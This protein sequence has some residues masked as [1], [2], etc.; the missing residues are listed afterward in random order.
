MLADLCGMPVAIALRVIDEPTIHWS[1]LMRDYEQFTDVSKAVIH[2]AM[3]DL[4]GPLNAFP[5]RR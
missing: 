2:T 4:L 5:S 1:R 3:S